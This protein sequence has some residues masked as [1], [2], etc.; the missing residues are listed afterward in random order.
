MLPPATPPRRPLPQRG[1]GRHQDLSDG[2]GGPARV[3]RPLPSNPRPVPPWGL[4]PPLW[5]RAPRLRGR[6]TP[7]ARQA[8]RADQAE[9]AAR[10]SNINHTPH[11]AQPDRPRDRPPIVKALVAMGTACVGD[12]TPLP[13][14]PPP[15]A[16][17][18]A[19]RLF[20]PRSPLAAAPPTAG[21]HAGAATLTPDRARLR[22][23]P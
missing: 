22:W 1:G 16:P 6:P 3:L 21:R 9:R 19:L 18:F 4:S 17:S 13:F 15:S 14:L 7:P 11:V 5:M 23:L 20:A 12:T 2:A 8:R 10:P